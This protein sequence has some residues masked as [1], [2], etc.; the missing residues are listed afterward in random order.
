MIAEEQNNTLLYG[1]RTLELVVI[2]QRHD[3]H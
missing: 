3:E 1:D 2:P